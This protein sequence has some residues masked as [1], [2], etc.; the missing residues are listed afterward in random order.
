MRAV[1]GR[2]TRPEV[3]LRRSLRERRL[4]GYR[5]SPRTVLGS[6]DVAFIRLKLAIFVD[7]CYWHGCPAH[8]R[9]PETN[10]DY[11]RRKVARNS[12]RDEA[13]TQ[14]LQEA[15]WRVLRF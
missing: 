11:W 4:L 1:R 9:L 15:G 8:C 3:Q 10:A 14:R 2:N 5:I 12:D 13:N 6:P 7:G